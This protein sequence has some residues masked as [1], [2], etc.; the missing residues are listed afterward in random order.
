M[1]I[2]IIGGD[3]MLGHQL[4]RQWDARHEVYVTLHKG[5][6][7][8]SASG[9]FRP[10][11]TIPNVEVCSIESVLSC[12]ENLK[13]DVIVNAAGLVKQRLT[14]KDTLPN[15]E[16]NALFPHRL[17]TVAQTVGA[18]VVH[19]S[20]DC[21]FSGRKGRY[22]EEDIPDPEDLYGRTKLLGE[23]HYSNCIT[24]RTSIVGRELFRKT[25]LLEWFLAQRGSVRGF[26]QAIYTG[27]T[28][29]ELARIV[30]QILI[31]HSNASGIW[32][33]SSDSISKHGLLG[34]FRKHFN[35]DTKIV[36]DDTFVCDRSLV[37]NRFR[38]AFGYAP[39]AWDDM[40]AELA[41]DDEFYR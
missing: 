37:S 10:E 33:V 26:R 35:L 24:L 36:P 18:R 3:G 2:L 32:H 15:L 14:V 27:F 31:H 29:I 34:L 5:P 6:P 1:K 28:T 16:I 38:S 22:T 30:E 8:F 11:R 17:A 7:A 21:V 12:A 9:L 25:G 39:P 41:Q 23:L 13:P 4:L 20:T 40:V 19:F